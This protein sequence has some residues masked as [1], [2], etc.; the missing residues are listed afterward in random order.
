MSSSADKVSITGSKEG[1][2]ARTYAES[3]AN[4][5]TEGVECDAVF[6]ERREGGV[7]YRS[8]GWCVGP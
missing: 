8:V 7:N 5:P 2:P 3:I 4:D 1:V 6:G